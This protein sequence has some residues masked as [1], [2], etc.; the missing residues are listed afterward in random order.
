MGRYGKMYH[1]LQVWLLESGLPPMGVLAVG[2]LGA[3]SE[4]LPA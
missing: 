2:N 3:V 4:V 1:D